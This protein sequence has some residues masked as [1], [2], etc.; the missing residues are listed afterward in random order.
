M[1]V[2]P[3]I[4]LPRQTLFELERVFGGL[5]GD[6]AS[7]RA[8]VVNLLKGR[9]EFRESDRRTDSPTSGEASPELHRGDP[10]ESD[11]PEA[12][13]PRSEPPHPSSPPGGAMACMTFE[14]QL[15][16]NAVSDALESACATSEWQ[17]EQGH[18]TERDD[19]LTH[20]RQ[21]SQIL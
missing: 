4:G 5:A 18:V 19:H 20:E 10:P 11:G 8:Y 16:S 17:A 1:T 14:V 15:T 6:I 9:P 13:V 12:G 21:P 3:V 2:K 7:Q